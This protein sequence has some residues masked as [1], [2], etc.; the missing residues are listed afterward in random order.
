MKT[1]LNFFLFLLNPIMGND[2]KLSIRRISAAYLVYVF[3]VAVNKCMSAEVLW[4]IAALI[5]VLL[6]LTTWQNI[7]KWTNQSSQ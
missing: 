2:D 1:I 4:V 3:S 7:Q 5:G 6:G